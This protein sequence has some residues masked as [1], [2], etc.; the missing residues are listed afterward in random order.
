MTSFPWLHVMLLYLLICIVAWRS[1]NFFSNSGMVDVYVVVICWRLLQLNYFAVDKSRAGPLWKGGYPCFHIISLFDLEITNEGR[2]QRFKKG[3]CLG[4][5]SIHLF[6]REHSMQSLVSQKYYQ[7]YLM[8]WKTLH[9]WKACLVLY[10][11]M[12][13][14]FIK[15]ELVCCSFY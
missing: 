8:L 1:N 7:I 6:C 9:G 5:S 11:Q 10:L 15:Y 14:Q 13:I 4:Q 12:V 2:K 3:K